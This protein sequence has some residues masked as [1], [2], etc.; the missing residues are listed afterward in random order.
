MEPRDQ[1]SFKIPASTKNRIEQLAEATGRTK[2]F[3]IEEAINQYILRNEWQI[4]SIRKGQRDLEEGKVVPQEKMLEY[5]ERKN[6][7]TKKVSL[8][9]KRTRRRGL[10]LK[11]GE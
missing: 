6:E 10:I 7:G 3:V 4:Q 2:T 1:V 8:L 11:R 9:L 5:W